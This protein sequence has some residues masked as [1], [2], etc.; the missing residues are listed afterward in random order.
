MWNFSLREK[1]EKEQSNIFRD[2]VSEFSKNKPMVLITHL[3]NSPR[4]IKEKKQKRKNYTKVHHN[5]RLKTKDKEKSYSSLSKTDIL[6]N[7]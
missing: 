2:N 1:R 5:Q 6:Q 7:N 4:K 3:R